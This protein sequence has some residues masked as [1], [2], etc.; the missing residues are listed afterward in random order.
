M[1]EAFRAGFVTSGIR[2]ELD[3]VD[4]IRPLLENESGVELP[5]IVVVGNTSVGKS[6]VLEAI[7]GVEFPKGSTVTTTC[8]IRLTLR[9]GPEF[10]ASVNGASINNKSLIGQ[11]IRTAM[12]EAVRNR[13]ATVARHNPGFAGT[14]IEVKLYEPGLPDLTLLDLPG[15]L[16]SGVAKDFVKT[17][18]QQHI[19]YEQNVTVCVLDMTS[20]L[21]NQNAI[22]WAKE[23]DPAGR[24]TLGIVTKPDRAVSADTNALD[25]LESGAFLMG[26]GYVVVRNRDGD[27]LRANLS[28]DEAA[29]RERQFFSGERLSGVSAHVSEALKK[30]SANQKGKQALIDLLLRVQGSHLKGSLIPFR[31]KGHRQNNEQGA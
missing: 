21:T 26:L 17:L 22:D 23:A 6:S 3:L 31:R 12:E 19:S 30:L 29:E 13:P 1:S 24:R 11:H 14:V 7:S 27:E 8:P 4:R 15:I 5:G 9:S 2:E 18:I 10:A 28:V 16:N 20:H 25:Q